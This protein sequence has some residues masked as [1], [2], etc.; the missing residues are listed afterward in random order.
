MT[1]VGYGDMYPQ[2]S[3]GYFIGS[4]CAVAGLL[5]IAFT[6]P[7]IV[8]NFVLYYTHVQYGLARR[9]REMELEEEDGGGAGA[10]PQSTPTWKTGT[11]GGRNSRPAEGK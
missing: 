4:C 2:S 11:A 5:M 6:V 10:E 7:I 3:A 1:T 9:D 8:S